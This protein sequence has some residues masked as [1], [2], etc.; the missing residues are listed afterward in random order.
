M[1]WVK[2]CGLRER[3]HV[4][5]A[6]E[7]GADAVGF[8]LYDGSPRHVTVA[9]AFALGEDVPALR[10]AVTVDLEPESLLELAAGIGADA[11]QPHGLHTVE[12]AEAAHRAGFFVLFP[13][14]VELAVDLSGV[15]EGT[16]P[17]L[18][19]HRPGL[20]GGT[21][22]KFEWALAEGIDRRFVLAGG[23]GP[24]SVAEGVR[25]LHPWGVDASSGLES[26]PGQQ[27]PKL[28]RRYVR[29]AKL[30]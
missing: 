30:A 14:K 10:V 16:I 29:E 27:D 1:T 28:I 20:H 24:D 23:L 4:E 21:G 3:P 19:A 15:P 17:L 12:A 2:V 8:V 5:T 22:T 25:Q 11:V 13:V 7:A 6:V 18:D 26:A 9:E